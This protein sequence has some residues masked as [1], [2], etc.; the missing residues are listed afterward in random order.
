MP[1]FAQRPDPIFLP[2]FHDALEDL[3]EA[4]TDLEAED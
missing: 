1:R 4:L 3:Q 2:I